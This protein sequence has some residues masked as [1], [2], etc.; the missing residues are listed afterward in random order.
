[1]EEKRYNK[2]KIEA[3]KD[4]HYYSRLGI[5]YILQ[6]NKGDNFGVIYGYR[7]HGRPHIEKKLGCTFSRSV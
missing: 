6:G 5:G 7:N 1:M 3:L 4:S 2:Y